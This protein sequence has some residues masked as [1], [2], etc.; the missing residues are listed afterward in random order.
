MNVRTIALK[1]PLATFRSDSHQADTPEQGNGAYEGGDKHGV[2]GLVGDLYGAKIDIPFLVSEGETAGGESDDAE[3][4]E[5]KSQDGCELHG[6]CL[7]CSD[8]LA[9]FSDSNLMV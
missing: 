3:E 4:D 2:L 9:R 7:S 1:F 6:W 8:D 5:K